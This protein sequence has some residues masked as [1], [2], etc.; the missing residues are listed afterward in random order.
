M[1][2]NLPTLTYQIMKTAFVTL[3]GTSA[4]MASD[5]YI[6]DG[7]EFTLRVMLD[8][9]GSATSEKVSMSA[10]SLP[11]VTGGLTIA[12]TKDDRSTTELAALASRGDLSG[13]RG[14]FVQSC[15][16]S[17][18]G[19]TVQVIPPN[20]AAGGDTVLVSDAGSCAERDY[21]APTQLAISDRTFTG[22]D[23]GGVADNC[24][25]GRRKTEP[26]ATDLT[27]NVEFTVG[28]V[29]SRLAG[30]VTGSQVVRAEEVD[31]SETY[32]LGIDKPAA[33]YFV[34]ACENCF[35]AVKVEYM[36]GKDIVHI[37]K[38]AGFLLTDQLTTVPDME[39]IA[40]TPQAFDLVLAED[41]Y[42]ISQA[43]S[44]QD[45]NLLTGSIN[46]G[47]SNYQIPAYISGANREARCR[48]ILPTAHAVT[49]NNDGVNGAGSI[50][51][52]GQE[53]DYTWDTSKLNQFA[54]APAAPADATKSVSF[55][56]FGKKVE[57]TWSDGKTAIVSNSLSLASQADDVGYVNF[58]IET[59][60]NCDLSVTTVNYGYVLSSAAAY[61]AGPTI[62]Q[63]ISQQY[64]KYQVSA[65]ADI[66]HPDVRWCASGGDTP[67]CGDY[68]AVRDGQ[69]HIQINSNVCDGAGAND[70]GDQLTFI[71]DAGATTYLPSK[72]VCADV[73]QVDVG[74]VFLDYR[75]SFELNAFDNAGLDQNFIT[76]D[77]MAGSD[78]QGATRTGE[79]YYFSKQAECQADG[80]VGTGGFG[81]KNLDAVGS[82]VIIDTYNE[83]R[84]TFDT[85]GANNIM[86][87]NHHITFTMDNDGTVLKFCNSKRLSYSVEEQSGVLSVS[88]AVEQRV[89][90]SAH[91][92]LNNMR[93]EQCSGGYQQ[94]MLLDFSTDDAKAL[95]DSHIDVTTNSHLHLDADGT[96]LAAGR[97]MFKS[98]CV[99]VCTDPNQMN[100]TAQTQFGIA[101][102]GSHPTFTVTS[103][104]L[105]NPCADSET[106]DGVPDLVL[107]V[108]NEATCSANAPD[109]SALQVEQGNHACFYL[110]LE[111]STTDVSGRT[112]EADWKLTDASGNDLTNDLDSA[113]ITGWSQQNSIE[114][115]DDD[116]MSGETLTL[117]VEYEQERTS[118]GGY[119]RL[120]A[121]YKLGAKDAGE[122]DASFT[123]LPSHITVQDS[124]EESA[125]DADA[126]DAAV[127]DEDPSWIQVTTL[128][129]VA[130]LV[131]AVLYSMVKRATG[132]A[133]Q[134]Q[135]VMSRVMGDKAYTPVGRFTSTIKY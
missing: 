134:R 75:V 107:K 44:T 47:S 130:V 84:D 57:L 66:R 79:G 63:G 80:T 60:E 103:Q 16:I 128:S 36:N 1:Q 82:P 77:G 94:M 64:R 40:S 108:S 83:I 93:W 2:Y 119:R 74:A 68:G 85:C 116:S 26:D 120:R 106:V 50:T 29:D 117:H 43:A 52:D 10:G 132:D 51:V 124:V 5:I 24:N 131:L 127:T 78:L 7:D 23:H 14:N 20:G 45:V 115:P 71:D 19:S 121:V 109:T 6:E 12:C 87:V 28:A 69:N 21:T 54:A 112:L 49:C 67:D 110:D 101:L 25:A 37:E 18:A 88:I 56:D 17:K 22:F 100:A 31:G 4:A 62:Q 53:F 59:R 65:Q 118:G 111:D 90:S 76:V 8:N 72:V 81:C 42:A 33:N 58:D 135:Q 73:T 123:V 55:A 27:A 95:D 61:A 126:A 114:I 97:I 99:D 41:L 125:P 133:I 3:L 15:Q 104:M 48:Q 105:G 38:G 98:S 89:G 11:T 91:V 70:I 102:S 46:C 9:S 30:F 39:R 13:F 113:T 35:G 92:E 129:L 96:N 34:G 122:A 32:D 86:F